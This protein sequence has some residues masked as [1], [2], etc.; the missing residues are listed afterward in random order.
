MDDPRLNAF[1]EQPYNIEAEKALLGAIFINNRAYEKVSEYLKPE[2]FALG[3]NGLIYQAVGDLID[4]GNVA[5]P[6]TLRAVFE[7]D[8][9][10]QEIGG[11]EYLRQLAGA[12]VGIINAGQYGRLIFDMYQRRELIEIGQGLVEQACDG[13][14]A[15]RADQIIS[16]AEKELCALGEGNEGGPRPIAYFVDEALRDAEAAHKDGVSG[17]STGFTDLDR[18]IGGLHDTDLVILAARPAMGKSALALNISMHVAKKTPLLFFSLEMGGSQLSLR[19]MT[20]NSGTTTH[21]VRTGKLPDSKWPAFLNA[22]KHIKEL[23]M[24]IDDRSALSVQQIRSAARRAKRQHG[25]GLIVVD[26][27]QIMR[28][29]A[30]S[31]VAEVSEISRGLKAIAK[32][33]HVPVLALSQLSRAVENRD[34]K[35]PILSDL[36]LSGS[37]EQDADMVMFLYREE[38]YLKQPERREKDTDKSFATRLESYESRMAACHGMAQVIVAKQRHGPTDTIKLRWDAQRTRFTNF[39]EYRNE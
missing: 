36:R 14:V 33:L 21:M 12:A 26:Y 4:K 13:N 19:E 35:R 22:S 3:Q 18:I 9:G 2:H 1:R 15:I 29:K 7:S 39:E 17:L 27:I 28:E 6:V 31:M 8:D 25:I 37:I 38:Y 5:D 11:G 20:A 24:M 32:E 23:P 34:D 16:D 30:E 10:L